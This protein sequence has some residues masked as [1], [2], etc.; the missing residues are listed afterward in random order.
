MILAHSDRRLCSYTITRFAAAQYCRHIAA[1][2][3]GKPNLLHWMLLAAAHI[4]QLLIVAWHPEFGDEMIVVLKPVSAS[5]YLLTPFGVRQRRKRAPPF[6]L[7]TLF[8]TTYAANTETKT[9][10]SHKKIPQ[11]MNRASFESI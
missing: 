10:R 2:A 5:H 7:N 4:V 6:G 3:V 11:K 9:R 1:A 8:F